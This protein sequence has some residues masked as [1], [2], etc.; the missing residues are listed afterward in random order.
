M[1][2]DALR[3]LVKDEPS[4]ELVYELRKGSPT[5]DDLNERFGTV[6]Q[7]IDILTCFETQRTKTVVKDVI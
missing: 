2:V 1:N 3:T 7:D 5:L 6:A 4:Q